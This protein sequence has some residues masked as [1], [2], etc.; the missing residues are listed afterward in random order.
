MRRATAGASAARSA[1][2]TAMCRAPSPP[3]A[4]ARRAARRSPAGTTR[5]RAP[6]TSATSSRRHARTRPNACT[7]ASAGVRPSTGGT[8]AGTRSRRVAC[9]ALG[10]CRAATSAPRRAT[11]ARARR[12]PRRW[13][14][15]AGAAPRSAAS[16]ARASQP[17][18]APPGSRRSCATPRARRS[19][20]A[21]ST[22]AD[23]A[24]ARLPRSRRSAKSAVPGRM[25]CSW[26]P[27]A[28]THA[29]CAAG[30]CLPAG[31]T[32][33]SA[34]ATGAPVGRACSLHL[35]RSPVHVAAPCWSRQY[36]AAHGSSVRTRARGRGRLAA[37][38]RCRT[39]ATRPRR[40][41]R[42]AC[43]SRAVPVP[44]GSTSCRR[45]RA[46]ALRCA[47]GVHVAGCLPVACTAANACATRPKKAA[48]PV[49]TS[50]DSRARCVAT[51]APCRAM[52]RSR[53]RRKSRALRWWCASAHVAT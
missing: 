36:H 18:T 22:S 23:S 46:A 28:S 41:V 5:A 37:T 29:R 50:V 48:H 34:S 21:A 51:P 3:G 52:H 16:S 15:C 13:C 53:A 10:A 49:H 27:T 25:P 42:L 24:A 33:A 8:T 38:P 4:A 1:A 11:R 2:A 47:A 39:A 7:P 17:R 45:C 26:T 12:A 20:T 9:R 14:R 6:A 35:R 40:R 43:T 19:G 44:A 32:A 31:A 30:A